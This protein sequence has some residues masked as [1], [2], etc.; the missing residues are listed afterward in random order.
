MDTP[1][2]I[3]EGPTRCRSGEAGDGLAWR[4]TLARRW[5]GQQAAVVVVV[6][7]D[8]VAARRA[9]STGASPAV[10]EA[11]ASQG[12]A[13]VLEELS[14]DMPARRLVVSLDGILSIK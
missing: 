11:L 1:W 4:W 5:S 10:A 13:L 7:G 12:R 9:E 8:A 2:A 3:I 6:T 14:R